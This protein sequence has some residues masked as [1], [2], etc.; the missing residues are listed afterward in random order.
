MLQEFFDPSLTQHI[1]AD[2][3]FQ[4]PFNVST[5]AFRIYKH[6]M[7]DVLADDTIAHLNG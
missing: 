1:Y 3:T 5:P 7:H 4:K 6:E 2:N